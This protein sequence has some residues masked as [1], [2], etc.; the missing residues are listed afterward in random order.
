MLIKEN[1]LLTTT[2]TLERITSF[3]KLDNL[4]NIFI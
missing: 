3:K 1:I 2:T 4:G